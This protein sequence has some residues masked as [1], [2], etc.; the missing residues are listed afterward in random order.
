MEA[1]QSE[2]S[3]EEIAF[4]STISFRAPRL[5]FQFEELDSAYTLAKENEIP[6]WF[7]GYVSLGTQHIFLDWG[8][9]NYLGSQL[10]AHNSLMGE[11][12][13]PMFMWPWYCE[14]DWIFRSD[15]KKHNKK[16]YKNTMTEGF[17][18]APHIEIDQLHEQFGHELSQNL[19]IT[20]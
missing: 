1:S 19:E 8:G 17:Y 14:W 7:N 6:G 18:L 15:M 16:K 4:K 11:E 10:D 13:L 12:S 3:G 9:T 20:V 2:H 5:L